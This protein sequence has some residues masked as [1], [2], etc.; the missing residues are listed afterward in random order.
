MANPNFFG[1][2]GPN[3]PN[4][5]PIPGAIPNQ[6]GGLIVPFKEF[7][8]HSQESPQ[9]SF[10]WD[11]GQA[12]RI[13]DVDWDDRYDAIWQIL[14]YSSYDATNNPNKLFKR[15]LPE[16]HPGFPWLIAT[17]INNMQGWGN[18]GTGGLPTFEL[19][20]GRKVARYTK[21]RIKV[22][23]EAPNFSIVPDSQ[24]WGGGGLNSEMLRYVD[25]QIKPNADYLTLPQTSF[26]K[27]AP[28]AKG[29]PFQPS[30][31][32][33]NCDFSLTWHQVP[34]EGIP[35]NNILAALGTVNNNKAADTN[36]LFLNVNPGTLLLIGVSL[37]RI[38]TPYGTW[39]W[40]IEYTMRYQ[41][42]THTSTDAF[43]GVD[44]GH[45]AFIDW[46]NTGGGDKTFDYWQ[47][48][49]NGSTYAI[50][51]ADPTAGTTIFGVSDFYKLF[52]GP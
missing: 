5:Q 49:T 14:G 34:Y 40:T 20:G 23:Y 24:V 50:T 44:L 26:F 9:E 2:G 36:G 46:N 39:A 29:V 47:V 19:L 51:T 33:G 32:V 35:F 3:D 1:G 22:E 37:K 31:I 17:K 7:E 4:P 18:P 25:F 21:C 41:K 30:K 48:T 11:Y 38:K 6:E 45:N 13:F 15:W 8:G 43:T 28:S 52:Q 12:T 42:N 16:V 10:G 27:W